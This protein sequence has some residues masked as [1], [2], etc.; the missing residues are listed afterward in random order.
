MQESSNNLTKLLLSWYQANARA[1]PWRTDYKPY[2]VLV[3]EFMLQQTQMERGVIYF[4]NWM[5]KFPTITDLAKASE[6]EVLRMWEGLGYYRRAYYL[7]AI[8]KKVHAEYNGVI[9]P[10]REIL[11]TFKGLGDYTLAAICGIAYNQPIVTIDANVE[12]VFSRLFC[13]EGNVK[14]KPAKD[15]IKQY[16]YKFLD[17]D[18]ARQYNQALMELGAL[19]CKKKAECNLCPLSELCQAYKTSSQENFPTLAKPQKK[20]Y[21]DWLQLII[22]T[23]DNKILLKQRDKSK[24]WGGLFE[25]VSLEAIDREHAKLID[26]KLLELQVI[27]K[28]IMYECTIP[29][30]YTNHKNTVAF[31]KVYIEE[32]SENLKNNYFNDFIFIEESNLKSYA[33]PSPYRKAIDIIFAN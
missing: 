25:F 11:A 13:I 21:E 16:A 18:N 32:E 15:L 28:E 20:I 24:H 12:R 17:K 30:T 8:A 9:P 2:H 27:K 1:L 19:I 33:L 6:E 26:K 3:S 14:T 5:K 22:I 23:N 31:Y 7:H 29:Y 10:S 4:N